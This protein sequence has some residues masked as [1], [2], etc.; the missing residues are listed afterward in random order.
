MA[1]PGPNLRAGLRTVYHLS[2]QNIKV[3]ALIESALPNNLR[4]D[5]S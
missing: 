1:L 2:F 4:L 3:A 5:L